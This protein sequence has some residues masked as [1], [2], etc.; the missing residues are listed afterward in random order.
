MKILIVDN[1]T[2]NSSHLKKLLKGH[3]VE[4]R[5]Y[6]QLSESD[7][8]EYD[9]FVLT[10]TTQRFMDYIWNKWG[11]LRVER[12]LILRTSKPIIGIC[13]GAELIAL[14][15]NCKLAKAETRIKGNYEIEFDIDIGLDLNKK[16]IV[17]GNHRFFISE[18]SDN[19]EVIAHSGFG[20]EII[21]HKN[22]AVY[23]FL[24]HPEKEAETT[25][26]DEIFLRILGNFTV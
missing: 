25:D 10:G 19:F 14:T 1:L 2:Q 12:D 24:F 7:F 23:G 5:I 13:Y 3:N 15:N 11:D 6:E 20:P 9:L 26:G 17:Y 18:T 8:E 22:K 4:F 16:Y 21:K